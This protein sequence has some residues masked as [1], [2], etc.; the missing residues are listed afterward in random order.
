MALWFFRIRQTV[1]DGGTQLV[2]K[3]TGKTFFLDDC[4]DCSESMLAKKSKKFKGLSE[5]ELVYVVVV[6]VVVFVVVVQFS[7][8]IYFLF[9]HISQNI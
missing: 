7:F 1:F 5:I 8:K 2:L 6:D 9:F 3:K 4:P